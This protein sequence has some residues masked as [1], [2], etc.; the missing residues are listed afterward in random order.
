MC[1]NDRNVPAESLPSELIFWFDKGD[2]EAPMLPYLKHIKQF[3][4]VEDSVNDNKMV[5]TYHVKLNWETES[6]PKTFLGTESRYYQEHCRTNAL[7][8]YYKLD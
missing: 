7:S 5:D 4:T 2:N 1:C 3:D 8:I 6:T